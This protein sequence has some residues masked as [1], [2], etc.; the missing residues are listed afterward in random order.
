MAEK[1]AHH[2][3]TFVNRPSIFEVIAQENFS[4]TGYPALK[5]IFNYIALKN[6]QRLN[7][8]IQHFDEVFLTLNT[9]CQYYY[10]KKYGGTFSE[11]FYDLTR[12]SRTNN[13][14]PA[15]DQLYISLVLTV[16]V[17]YLQN[18]FDAYIDQLQTKYKLQLKE[19]VF[20][21]LNK[22]FHTC[23]ETV[24]LIYYI[25]YINGSSQTHSVLLDVAGMVLTYKN[26]KSSN[27]ESLAAQLSIR[28]QIKNYLYYGISHS[29]ELGAFFMQF[30]NW[31]HSENLQSKFIAY[32]IPNP[33]KVSY[34][35]LFNYW[36]IFYIRVI[37]N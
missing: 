15:I 14:K 8:L 20:I 33:P 6:P 2:T 31:W 26:I 37:L 19:K 1:A 25:K 36:I 3:K 18:K 29:L 23:W 32:P 9:L 28:E 35:V 12:V 5:R 27:N 22:I 34:T 4:S 10:L 17:P 16:S 11:N 24:C 21:A 7:W 30:L 13:S